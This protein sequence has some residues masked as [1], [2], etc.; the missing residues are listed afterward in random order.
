M[1]TGP[2]SQANAGVDERQASL[3]EDFY[4]D[5]PFVDWSMPHLGP[6]EFE[7]W[8]QNRNNIYTGLSDRLCGWATTLFPLDK[9]CAKNLS[10]VHNGRE[11]VCRTIA[12]REQRSGSTSKASVAYCEVCGNIVVPEKSVIV[13]CYAFEAEAH[14]NIRE[15][16]RDSWLKVCLL[17]F[18]TLGKDLGRHKEDIYTNKWNARSKNGGNIT[19]FNS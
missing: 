10:L 2:I 15:Q 6:F 4:V 9:F 5:Y 13:A 8:L 18:L 17:H 16:W 3:P 14:P 1:K 12:M 19:L 11:L 7:D